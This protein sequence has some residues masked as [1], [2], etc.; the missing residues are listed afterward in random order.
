MSNELESKFK[1]S[2]ESFEKN[3]ANIRTGRASPAMVEGVRIELYGAQTALKAAASINTSDVRTLKVT[4][5][6]PKNINAIEKALMEANLGLSIR[7][8]GHVIHLGFPQLTEERRMELAKH[9]KTEA[10]NARVAMR[11]Q[12]RDYLDGLKK[13][14]E[15]SKDELKG[16]DTS[17]QKLVDVFMKKIDDAV[18]AKEKAIAQV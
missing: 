3:L 18:A 1:K 17:V 2:F 14:G 11:N 15:L 5:F 13:Q 9:A 8:D 4:P 16:A 7:N 12:R 10:E 6:D